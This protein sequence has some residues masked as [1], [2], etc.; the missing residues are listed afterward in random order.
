MVD[1]MKTEPT[2][3]DKISR[4]ELIE[5]FGRKMPVDGLDILGNDEL[6]VDRQRKLLRA[7]KE[8]QDEQA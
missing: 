6:T 7:L 2:T 4:E 8:L 1:D 5:L 3:G